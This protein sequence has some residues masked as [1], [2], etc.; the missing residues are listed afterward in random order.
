M[1]K[2]APIVLLLVLYAAV[3][4]WSAIFPKDYFTWLLEVSPGVLGLFVL[5]AT[6]KRFTFSTFTY[7]LIL[8]HCSILFVGGHYTYAEVPLFNWIRD[9]YSLL[10]NDYDKVG[11]VVQGFVPALV[12][13]EVFIRNSIV[14]KRGWLSFIVISI[15]LAISACYELFEWLVAVVSGQS[16]EAFL[17]TQGDPWDT[18][19]DM[20][21]ALVGATIAMVFLSKIQDR[22]IKANNA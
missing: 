9:H 20:L 13:R 11:H 8:L 12:I 14:K 19:S 5:I 15:C 3:L 17:G 18:Q 7:C 10:R 21:C 22:F 2:R 4:L 6:F 16:A 1:T